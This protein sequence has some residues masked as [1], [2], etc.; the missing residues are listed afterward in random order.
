MSEI[1][2]LET[3]DA[4]LEVRD[5]EKRELYGRII[6]YGETIMV[7]GRKESFTKGALAHI[8]PS[9]TVLLYM[10]DQSK[11]VGRMLALEERD[12]GAYAT[13]KVAR[14]ALGDELLSLAADGV[15]KGMSAGFIPD[16]QNASGVHTRIKAL[17]ETSLVTFGAYSGAQVLAVRDANNSLKEDST[18][19]DEI[20]EATE[21]HT[22]VDLTSIEARLDDMTDKL[23]KLE[24]GVSA[25]SATEKRAV[26]PLDWFRAELDAVVLNNMEKRMQLRDL[27]HVEGIFDLST[28][29]DADGLVQDSYLA[30]QLVHILD[31]RRPFF[32]NL[33]AFPMPK[34]GYA[35]IPVV[36]QGTNVTARN[37]QF[38]EP[39]TREL[40]VGTQSFEAQWFSGAVAIAME[41]IQTS[42]PAVLQL[43]WEDLLGRYAA[44]VE[45]YAITT[46]EAANHA[47]SGAVLATNT[48]AAFAE[49]VATEAIDIRTAT[50]APAT[51]LAVPYALW[52]KIVAMVD[53]N[54]R[55]QFASGPYVD[56]QNNIVAESFELAGG[57]TVFAAG[58][59]NALLFN[60]QAIRAADGG[61]SRV[62]A[63]AVNSM[64]RE[65]GLLGRAMVV[66]R[67]PT[68]IVSFEAESSSSS[69][70]SSSS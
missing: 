13:F 63:T 45:A 5:V 55:R 27:A 39:G 44:A 1:I 23:I 20:K 40:L 4:L 64:S 26:E 43:V 2:Q 50:G 12:D 32:R 10:H 58:V 47:I 53:G 48:Y 33:G 29:G 37:A 3:G 56:G 41:L 8:N 69:S 65:I 19:T 21:V 30:G 22:S 35:K 15:L 14:T 67:I 61:P 66:P 60:E 28:P 11:P 17:P 46:V 34:S 49:A 62:E 16:I 59:T 54:D 25:P 57:I 31:A 51:K 68:G 52:P 36:S 70:S 38:G 18:L 24:M 9:D 7:R 42:D 6:P